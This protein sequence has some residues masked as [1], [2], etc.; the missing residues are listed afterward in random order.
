MSALMSKIFCLIGSLLT[1]LIQNISYNPDSNYHLLASRTQSI[2]LPSPTDF[3]TYIVNGNLVIDLRYII[4]GILF[5]IASITDFVDGRVARK[6]NMVTEF[7]KMVDAISDKMLT[8]S[9]LVILASTGM[10]SP[11]LAVIFIVMLF[12]ADKADR[13]ELHESIPQYEIITEK[14]RI[15]ICE[16]CQFIL[17]NL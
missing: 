7:G 10:I 13:L 16:L 8:N 17:I 11:V 14:L 5:V 1:I 9:L 6:Y 3:P 4:A 15:G 2:P 12:P